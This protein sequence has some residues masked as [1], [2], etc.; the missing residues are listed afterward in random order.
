MV[1]IIGGAKAAQ[2]YPKIHLVS[3]TSSCH[4][5]TLLS[6]LFTACC[7]EYWKPKVDLKKQKYDCMTVLLS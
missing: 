2:P 6:F 7:L 3:C 4:S 5:A 1:Q